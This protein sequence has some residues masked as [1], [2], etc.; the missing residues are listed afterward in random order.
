LLDF[1]TGGGALEGTS[2]VGAA[3]VAG[4]LAAGR[5]RVSV[6]AI[7]GAAALADGVVPPG[8]WVAVCGMASFGPP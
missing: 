3:I 4:P 5:R 6:E 7:V 2:S 1:T 8:I